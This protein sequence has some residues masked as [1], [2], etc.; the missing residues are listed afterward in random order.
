MQAATAAVQGLM[1]GDLNAALANGTAPFIANEI[2]NLIPGDDADAN[3]KRTIA[4][5]IAHGI[6]N[7]ALA[8]AKGENAAAQA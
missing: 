3:L 5:G 2:K 6:V 8:L 7:A 4:H 1:N